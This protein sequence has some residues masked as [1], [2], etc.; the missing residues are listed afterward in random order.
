M[1]LSN[2]VGR[3][4]LR[5][6]SKKEKVYTP[7]QMHHHAP[8]EHTVDGKNYD[9]ELHIVHTA[10]NNTELSVIGIFFDQ[11]V[12]GNGEN[13]FLQKIITAQDGANTTA[14][15]DWVPSAV[16]INNLLSKL[17]KSKLVHYEG[18]LTTPPC[19]EIVEWNVFIDPQPIST[20]QLQFFTR[21]WAGNSTFAQGRG[22]NR[23]VQ[24]IGE[25]YIYLQ[26]T[27]E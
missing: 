5:D 11:K 17:D 26:S 16:D 8:S 27:S 14:V 18:S 25:R 23:R 1:G 3:L 13:E 6:E 19:A 9:M 22:N 7:L 21:N 2:F 10:K 12:G 24:A 15:R 4:V 20:A